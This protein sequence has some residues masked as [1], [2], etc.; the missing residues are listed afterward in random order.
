[1]M[2]KAGTQEEVIDHPCTKTATGFT[3]DLQEYTGSKGT[4]RIYDMPGIGESIKAD[5]QYYNLYAEILPKA[6]VVIW[7]PSPILL[8]SV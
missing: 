4:M 7:T 6:D 2:A 1:M 5:E 8:V 3:F